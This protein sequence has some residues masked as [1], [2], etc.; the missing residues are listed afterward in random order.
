M[1]GWK[2]KVVCQLRNSGVEFSTRLWLGNFMK[3]LVLTSMLVDVG[4]GGEKAPATR[5]GNKEIVFN[6]G[7]PLLSVGFIAEN[8]LCKESFLET[9][10]IFKNIP[11]FF[12]LN[13][14]TLN[15]ELKNDFYKVVNSMDFKID[16]TGENDKLIQL[17]KKH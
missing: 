14:L 3:C 12:I 5:F 6:N 2:N 9:I 17:F 4:A 13:D 10:I 15:E 1:N 11:V 16:Y 7:K 8:K